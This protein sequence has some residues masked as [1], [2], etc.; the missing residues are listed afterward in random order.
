M[1][2]VE[3]P[4][5][6]RATHRVSTAVATVILKGSPRATRNRPRMSG[7]KSPASTIRLKYRT[8]KAIMMPVGATLDSPWS[9][10]SPRSPAKPPMSAADTG[11]RIRATRTEARLVMVSNSRTAIVAKPRAASTAALAF[12]GTALGGGGLGGRKRAE[13]LRESFGA[14]G[15]R[16]PASNRDLSMR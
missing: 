10:N 15:K 4:S 13:V 14:R 12:S 3:A 8:A 5:P 16:C 9:V 6:S 1:R 11:S 7:S 2:K